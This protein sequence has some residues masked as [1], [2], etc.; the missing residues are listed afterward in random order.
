MSLCP[1]IYLIQPA[2][3]FLI[4]RGQRRCKGRHFCAR[5]IE[6]PDRVPNIKWGDVWIANQIPWCSDTQQTE[7]QSF[8]FWRLGPLIVDRTQGDKE[9]IA[10]NG[11]RADVVNFIEKNDDCSG[12]R[13]DH[14]STQI[15]SQ[16]V[17]R[18]QRRVLF[19]ERLWIGQVQFVRQTMCEAKIPCTDW[20][21]VGGPTQRRQINLCAVNSDLFEPPCSPRAQ[22]RL[23]DLPWRQHCTKLPA[24]KRGKQ[25]I[26]CSTFDV[27]CVFTQCACRLQPRGLGCQFR[28][29]SRP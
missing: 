18:Q 2:R 23:S 12:Q 13:R 14:L 6:Q 5:E 20:I 27:E 9:L 22:T 10:I 17:C 28:H 21:T 15:Q 3:R 24:R 25:D 26:I 19:K 7:S 1:A 29:R 11:K 4:E 8:Q 16:S